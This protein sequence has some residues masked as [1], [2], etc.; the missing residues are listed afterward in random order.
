VEIEGWVA[1]AWDR[2]MRE[3]WVNGW[4]S[5]EWVDEEGMDG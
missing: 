2:W 1:N 5:G 3:G 4:L